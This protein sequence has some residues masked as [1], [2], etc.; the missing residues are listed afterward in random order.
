MA[1]DQ[2]LVPRIDLGDAALGTMAEAD[3]LSLRAHRR[4]IGTLGLLMPALIYLLAGVRPTPGLARWTPQWSVSAYYYTGAIG[5]FV[6][7]LFALSLFLFSYQGYKGVKAD[8]IV[9]AVAGLAALIVALFPTAAPT[10]LFPPPWWNDA[11]AVVHYVAAVVLFGSFI[12]FAMW[13]FR[14]SD[15]PT[16]R[17]RSRDKNFRDDVCLVCGL[18]MIVCL[19]WAAIAKRAVAPIF[20]P[21]S[22]AIVAFAVSWLAKGEAHTPM[23]HAAKKLM[24]KH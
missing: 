17:E 9:G 15:K 8:R 23:I 3:Q 4:I 18:V 16:R 14:R 19:L 22:I 13:L 20:W 1:I 6:G 11:T 21:E 2:S 7:V 12:V 10:G 24:N 5:V